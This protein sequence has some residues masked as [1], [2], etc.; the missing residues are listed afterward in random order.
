MLKKL[1]PLIYISGIAIIALLFSQFQPDKSAEEIN[2][3]YAD[4]QSK[5]VEIDG[6]KVHYKIEGKGAPLI[7]IHGTSSSLH[8]WDAWSEILKP[9]FT[10]VRMDIP[11]FGLTG[12]HPKHDYSIQSYADFINKFSEALGL[13]TFYLAGNSLG[14]FISWYYTLQYPEK[15][16]KLILINAAGY[17]RENIPTL[18]KIARLPIIPD[19]LKNFTPKFIVKKNLQEVYY[20]DS[21][22]ND[23]LI[24]RYFE[25]SLRKGNRDAF[26]HRVKAGFSSHYSEIPNINTPTLIQWGKYDEWIPLKD[27]EHFNKDIFGSK[28]IVYNNAGHIPMEE[29]PFET[30]NDALTFLK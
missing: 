5:F 12:P 9:Y 19:I 23:A 20:D 18:F 6:M 14:G 11:A 27:G 15:V 30:A 17:P 21:K 3:K 25:L 4:S 7:L 10:I 1:L 8:T 22:I 2:A 16:K 28:L 13:D 29:I 24:E 26:L